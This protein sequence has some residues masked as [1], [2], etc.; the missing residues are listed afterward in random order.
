MMRTAHTSPDDTVERYVNAQAA[1][2]EALGTSIHI[3]EPLTGASVTRGRPITFT[4]VADS[5]EHNNPVISWSS[6]VQGTLGTGSTITL[7]T[8][9]LGTHVV[10]ATVTYDDGF[11]KIDRVTVNIVNLV[12]VV[13]IT[14]PYNG[15]YFSESTN[16]ILHGSSFDGDAAPDYKLLD[17]QVHWTLNGIDV[18]TGHSP[19]A[20]SAASIGLPV[21]GPYVLE[22]DGT[23]GVANV[24]DTVNINIKADPADLPPNVEIITPADGTSVIAD[25]QR[26]D[27]TWYKSF[28]LTWSAIDPED[29]VLPF[30]S[31]VWWDTHGLLPVKSTTITLPGSVVTTTMYTIE[32]E[33]V[34]GSPA[35]THKISVVATD[36][37]G[38]R[39]STTNMV[40]V[41]VLN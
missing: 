11:S 32:L 5:A 35:T 36:S 4:A 6:D 20:F 19:S 1:V 27:G 9:T 41:N 28:A 2:K 33:V 13:T 22:F 38:N 21:G 8:L 30:S 7:R 39:N 24:S 15:Q 17:S 23:D 10:T 16:I 31:L 12:P 14:Q 29:G 40:T 3:T 26:A 25:K 34:P 18:G 37:N